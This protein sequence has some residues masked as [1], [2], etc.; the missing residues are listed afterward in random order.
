MAFAGCAQA[1][2]HGLTTT[3]AR[4]GIVF[5]LVVGDG[6]V[7]EFGLGA[8]GRRSVLHDAAHELGHFLVRLVAIGAH[9]AGKVGRAGDDVTR[10]AAM[11][12]ADGDDGRLVGADFARDDGLQGVDNLCRHHNGVVAALGHGAV[13]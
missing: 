10:G 11:E 13:A 8:Q 3:L 5:D 9:R 6:V 1:L 12:L 4:G 2:D 7:G